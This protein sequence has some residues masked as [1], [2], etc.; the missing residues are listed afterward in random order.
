M[1][2]DTIVAVKEHKVTDKDSLKALKPTKHIQLVNLLDVFMDHDI[3]FLIYED[4]NASHVSLGDIKGGMS[5]SLKENEIAA[6]AEQNIFMKPFEFHLGT[7]DHENL[8]VSGTGHVKI[9]NVASGMLQ[10]D[11]AR[12]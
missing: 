7:I 3:L 12:Q 1:D 4:I 8:L 10:S 6:I 2:N 5:G 11:S 9:A